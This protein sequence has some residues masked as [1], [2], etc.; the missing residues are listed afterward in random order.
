MRWVEHLSEA[1]GATLCHMGMGC[2]LMYMYMYG[3]E[4]EVWFWS[5]EC[6]VWYMEFGTWSLIG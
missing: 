3:L 1:G 4:C 6:E 2:E 5:L